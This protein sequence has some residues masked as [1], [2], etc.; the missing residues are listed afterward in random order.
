MPASAQVQA[1]TLDKFIEGWKTFTAEAWMETWSDDCKQQML[2][3]TLGIPA[4]FR[5]ETAAFLP[6]LISVLKNYEMNVQHV[7]HDASR[8]KAAIYVTST[9]KTPWPDLDWTNEYA[10][11]LTFTEDG[12]EI[13][14]FEEMVDTAFFQQFFP[15]LQ[16]YLKEQVGSS[17]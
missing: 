14:K 3:S 10:V 8:N 9:A 1:A 17:H 7:V 13:N 16:Q 4:R 15:R 11:F 5:T 6:K 12:T 2:P